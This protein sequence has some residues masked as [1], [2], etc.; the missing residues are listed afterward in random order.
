MSSPGSGTD[1][2]GNFEIPSS[3]TPGFQQGSQSAEGSSF[4]EARPENPDPDPDPVETP[5]GLSDS[6]YVSQR[7]RMLDTVNRLRETG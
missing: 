5:V 4:V 7:R 6:R 2:D 1:L 3:P